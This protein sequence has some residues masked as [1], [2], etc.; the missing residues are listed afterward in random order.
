MITKIGAQVAFGDDAIMADP[1]ERKGYNRMVRAMRVM[2]PVTG[3]A[4]GA[5]TGY[6]AGG[7]LGAVVGAPLGALLSHG[8]TDTAARFA[9]AR[10]QGRPIRNVQDYIYSSPYLPE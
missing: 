4:A 10:M 6:A 2:Y 3:A 7:R 9:S 8:V 1:E 5:A